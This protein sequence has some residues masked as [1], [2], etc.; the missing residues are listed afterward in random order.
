[1][2][3]QNIFEV[4]LTGRKAAKLGIAPENEI[5]VDIISG[6]RH[7]HDALTRYQIGIVSCEMQ[8]LSGADKAAQLTRLWSDTFTAYANLGDL[9]VRW[10]PYDSELDRV[11]SI[12]VETERKAFALKKDGEKIDNEF[13]KLVDD[14]K[15][16][17]QAPPVNID[18]EFKKFNPP[19]PP[20]PEDDINEEAA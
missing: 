14:A 9:I 8:K 3:Q 20:K 6:A 2:E 12:E 10:K 18:E 13:K 4:D 16:K 11:I 17:E 5:V 1:M 19:T 7:L 15:A